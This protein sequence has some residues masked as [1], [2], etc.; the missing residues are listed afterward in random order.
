MKNVTK[1]IF[2][3][4][5]LFCATT[6]SAQE[7]VSGSVIGRHIFG[8]AV[9][10]QGDPVLLNDKPI[11]Y[12]KV[13]FNEHIEIDKSR[14]LISS[15]NGNIGSVYITQLEKEL[16]NP[17]DTTA[18]NLAIV[19]GLNYPSNGTKT[20]WNT[21]LLA[22]NTVIDAANAQNFIESFRPF[23]KGKSDLVNPY[24]YGWV[25]EIIVLDAKG[26]AKA[27]KSFSLGRLFADQVILMPDGKTVY[28]L[29]KLGNLYVFIGEQAN[30]LAKGKLYAVSRSNG[31]IKYEMLGKQSAL[32]VKFKLKKAKFSSIFKS[33]KPKNGKCKKKYTYVNTQFGE[34]CL[35]IQRKY[36]KYIGYFEPIRT[37]AIKGIPEFVGKDSNMHFNSKD[38]Y[39]SFKQNDQAELTLQLD[40]DSKLKSQFILKGP[41]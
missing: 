11:I 8:L 4:S 16:G 33:A 32:K 38:K 13:S 39:I 1:Y 41:L 10:Y 37:K 6:V 17:Q 29:D 35:K 27:I 28:L 26:A 15:F 12:E 31:K 25:S 24:K 36:K 9:D 19:D 5:T 34:E 2:L 30:S 3:L 20:N 18:L 14:F 21:I 7:L 40:Q 23:Y 22:E